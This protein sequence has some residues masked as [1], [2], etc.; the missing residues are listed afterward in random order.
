MD[1]PKICILTKFYDWKLWQMAASEYSPIQTTGLK[2]EKK[3]NKK[4]SNFNLH[5]KRMLMAK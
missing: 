3:T 5:L 4:M 2:C 1:C